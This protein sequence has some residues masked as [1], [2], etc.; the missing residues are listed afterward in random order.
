MELSRLPTEVELIY[1]VMPCNA[2]RTAQE[3]GRHPHPCSYFRR[4]GRYHSYDYAAEG[5]PPQPGIVQESVY[6]GRGPLVPE[7]L[8]GCRKAPILAVGIIYSYRAQ[9]APHRYLLYG[10]GGLFLMGLGIRAMIVG[11]T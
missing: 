1:E 8:S 5:P 9:L 2:L 11:A 10:L 7:V 3:P 4:W 6:V